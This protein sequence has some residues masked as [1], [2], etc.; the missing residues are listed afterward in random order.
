M[1]DGAEPTPHTLR[2]KGLA[3]AIAMAV[4]AFDLWSKAAVFDSL[5]LI[6]EKRWLFGTRWLGF[7]KVENPGVMWGQ[8]THWSG[9]LPWVRV[10]AA[11][12]VVGMLRTTPPRAR[13]MQVALGLVL[14]G[15]LGNIYDGL[16]AGGKVRDFLMVDF[17]FKPFAPFPIF[18][19][20]DSAI[21][22][23]VGLLALSM[24]RDRPEAT[25]PDAPAPPA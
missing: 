19:V 15:A 4:T 12:I 25:A 2:G 1:R 21:C 24:A 5:K 3:F 6:G 22:V 20:A 10:V 18:N 23:G 17:G 16:F 13:L 8:L 14:G 11:I 9:Y 7:M